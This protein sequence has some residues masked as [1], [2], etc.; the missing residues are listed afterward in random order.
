MEASR[1]GWEMVAVGV[2]GDGG[3]AGHVGPS[4][5]QA[6]GASI[7]KPLGRCS[8]PA[9]SGDSPAIRA[10]RRLTRRRGWPKLVALTA[11]QAD[12]CDLAIAMCRRGPAGPSRELAAGTVMKKPRILIVDADA[13]ARPQYRRGPGGARRAG[14]CFVA[15]PDA[16]LDKLRGES[17]DLLDRRRRAK[18]E[19]GLELLR[20]RSRDR[21]RTAADRGR[22]ARRTSNRPRPACGWAPAIIWPSRSMPQALAAQRRAAALRAAAGSRI[23]TAAPAGR[24]ALWL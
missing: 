24:A 10:P 14:V 16:A 15:A 5:S 11:I 8:E 7:D 17:F 19:Q 12:R 18:P 1:K 21:R 2:R 4:I 23:R 22:P 3:E 6:L 13:A 20:A 9:C